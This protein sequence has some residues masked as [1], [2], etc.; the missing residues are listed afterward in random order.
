MRYIAAPQRPTLLAL[1]AI[2]SLATPTLAAAQTIAITHARVHSMTGPP[3]DDATIV[4]RD[5]LIERVGRDVAVPAGARVVDATGAVVTPGLIDS[6]TQIGVVEIDAYANTADQAVSNDRITAAFNVADGYN[7][8]STLIPVTRVEGVTRAVVSPSARGSLI[9]GQGIVV[10]LGDGSADGHIVRS[11][12]GMFV[13]LGERGAAL[14]GGARGAAMLV[15]REALQDA[16]DYAAN[17]PAFDRNQRRDYA[18]S[19][20]DLEALVPVVEGRLPLVVAVDRASD[21]LAALRLRDEMALRMILMGGAEGWIVADAIAAA[22]VPVVVFPLQNIPA[23]ERLGAT[24]ENAGRLHAA[25][26]RVVIGTGGLDPSGASH[27]SRNLKHAAGVAAA[28]GMPWDAALGAITS[29]PAAVWGIDQ[30][31]G[32]ITPGADADLVVWSADPLE[33]TTLVRHVFIR[34]VEMPAT[35]RQ[36]LL[37]ERYREAEVLPQAYDRTAP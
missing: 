25:G 34:G 13:V 18:L 29:E 15:L 16:R 2:A 3:I 37:F 20:L 19:R 6:A 22:D 11:P 4:I 14:A 9:A 1:L 8:L 35:T 30:H 12:A 7:P 5:G 28:N 10:H 17:R 32:R 31:Y 24:L 33:L 27:N 23:F 21:I 26:V 36:R